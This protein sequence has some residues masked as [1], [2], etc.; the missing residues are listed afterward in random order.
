VKVEIS[1]H[2]EGFLF[3]MWTIRE[4]ISGT[5]GNAVSRRHALWRAK[6][7]VDQTARK[8]NPEVFEYEAKP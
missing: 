8:R 5:S 4:G 6:R 7:N 3:W 1:V 2:R